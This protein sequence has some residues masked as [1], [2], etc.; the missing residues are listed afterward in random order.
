MSNTWNLGSEVAH[1]LAPNVTSH[2][3]NT[4]VPTAG[5][6]MSKVRRSMFESTYEWKLTEH[7]EIKA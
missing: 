2:R 7:S 3:G 5:S 4:A 6:T 1:C